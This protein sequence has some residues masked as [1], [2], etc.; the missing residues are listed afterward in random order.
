MA[1]FLKPVKDTKNQIRGD[2]AAAIPDLKDFLA[3]AS[4]AHKFSLSQTIGQIENLDFSQIPN[5]NSVRAELIDLLSLYSG[6]GGGAA[7]ASTSAGNGGGGAARPAI[8]FARADIVPIKPGI[9]LQTATLLGVHP[10]AYMAKLTKEWNATKTPSDHVDIANE[11]IGNRALTN[12]QVGAFFKQFKIPADSDLMKNTIIPN[13]ETAGRNYAAVNPEA[14]MNNLAEEFVTTK[15]PSDRIVIVGQVIETEELTDNQVL[16]F[17][18][19][20]NLPPNSDIMKDGIR[21]EWAKNHRNKKVELM[22]TDGGG[23]GGNQPVIDAWFHRYDV[24]GK[25]LERPSPR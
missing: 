5:D 21:P 13:M 15:Y 8:P 9:T 18:E 17:L 19:K 6:S 25:R 1:L 3:N 14:Y 12:A 10:E 23:G 24:N 11:V 16:S 22:Q 4:S 7:A 2:R 20:L